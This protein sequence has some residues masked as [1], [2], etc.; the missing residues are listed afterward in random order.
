MKK[1]GAGLDRREEP[2]A[3]LDEDGD[4]LVAELDVHDRGH[5]LLARPQQSGAKHHAEVR[6][7]HQVLV[8]FH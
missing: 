7:R 4:D 2:L 6:G 8:T 3:V 1:L 5:S